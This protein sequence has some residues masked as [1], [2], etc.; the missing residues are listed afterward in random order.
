[1]F[2]ST[3]YTGRKTKWEFGLP[4][5]TVS[6]AAVSPTALFA[7]GHVLT[8]PPLVPRAVQVIVAARIVFEDHQ[9]SRG[10]SNSKC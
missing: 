2:F 8:G 5:A 1:M 10:L 6:I 9:L 4:E 7:Y 3:R